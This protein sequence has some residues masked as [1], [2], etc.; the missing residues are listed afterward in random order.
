MKLIFRGIVQGVGFRPTIYRIAC[1][2]GLK[3]YVLNRGSEVEVVIDKKE[4]DFI[5]EVKKN[6]PPIAKITEIIVKEDHRYFDDFRIL[7]S[8]DGKRQS[9]IPPDI[10][11]CEQCL[12]EIFDHNNRRYLYPFTNCTICGA[13]FT[14]IKNVPYDREHTSMEKF[15]LCS[16]CKKEY[17]DPSN[18]RYHAQTISCPQCGPSYRLYD[19]KGR[20]LG[21]KNAIK[22]F[23]EQI[24]R[25]KIGVIKS[26]GG[27]HICCKIEE[28]QHFRKWYKRPEKAFAVMVKD[29]KTAEKYGNITKDEKKLLLSKARPIVLVK[30]KRAEEVSPGLN[31]IGIYLPYTGVHHILFSHLKT[32]DA[33]IMTSANI[34]GEPMIIDNKDVFSLKA[35]FYL[36]HNRDI[37]NR[38]DDSVIKNWRGKTFFLRKSRGFVP[39]PVEVKYNKNI[40]SVGAE[41]N[42]CGAISCDKKIYTTQYIGDTKYYSTLD[43]LKNS[44]QHLIKLTMRKEKIDAIAT[45]LHPT[46]ST[47]RIAEMFAEKFSAP[48]FEVQHHWAHAASLLVDNNINEAV[49]LTLDGLGYVDDGAMWGGEVLISSLNHFKRVGH[50]EYIPLPGGDKAVEDPR[51]LVFAIFKKFDKEKYFADREA[52][53]LNKIIEKSPKTSSLGRILDAI[54]CYLGI[55]TKRTYD[56]EPAMK[57]EKYLAM[58]EKKHHFDVEIK[59]NNVVG[60]L[61][62]FRQLEEKIRHPLTE[63]QKADFAY[64]M[65]KTIMDS[66]VDI[67]VEHAE[68]NDIKTIGIS[69]GV[70]YN[71]PI[72][73]MVC[74]KVEKTGLSFIVHNRVPN[75]DGG[76]SVGQNAIIG[77]RLYT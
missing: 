61:D 4:E 77:T 56:G 58:G 42:V 22:R 32:T 73:E 27:M 49:I 5:K 44:L 31:T 60:T 33:L 35:D 50:L 2:M 8:R 34:P 76:I 46:Y 19:K 62:L 16:I 21:E 40:L 29:I 67:A 43:F 48:V 68:Q 75:G 24:D 41:E 38:T 11:I 6:L 66:L 36:L 59:N 63:K 70:S 57:L 37:P 7:H 47:R 9:L 1:K 26:W 52:V 69:G 18:R 12:L 72:V 45:D 51:R 17:N 13:R 25:G 3:G 55:C 64:S 53:V 30:K 10:G 23:A 74:R 20:E 71:I 39:E 54:S 28:A 65:V 15:R 14:L